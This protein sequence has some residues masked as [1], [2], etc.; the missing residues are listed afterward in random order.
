M[1]E[2]MPLAPL[3]A[4]RPRLV[5]DDAGEFLRVALICVCLRVGAGILCR[6]YGA[7]DEHWQALEAAHGLA[8]G[9]G[10]PTWEW[11][12]EIRL[13]SLAPVGALAG[14]AFTPLRTAALAVWGTDAA[15][16]LPLAAVWAAPRVA[17]AASALVADAAVYFLALSTWGG[18]ARAARAA[19]LAHAGSWPALI[20]GARAS[21]NAASA[22][23][24]A[25][26][27]A[28][29]QTAGW[30]GGRGECNAQSQ[31][32]LIPAL[33]LGVIAG[34][35][36]AAATVTHP[37]VAAALVGFAGAVLWSAPRRDGWRLAVSAVCGAV[38]VYILER[39]ADASIRG[40]SGDVLS[41][42]TVLS[43]PPPALA[44]VRA[45]VIEGVDS[46]SGSHFT[47]WYLIIGVPAVLG[48][49]A[50]A[51]VG[52]LC[53]AHT[54]ATR[55]PI[56]AAAALVAAL[57]LAS[58]KELRYLAPF[59]PLV[60]VYAGRGATSGGA[61]FWAKRW[62]TPAAI[63]INALAAAYV[64]AV[65]QRGPVAAV[66][67][68]AREGKRLLAMSKTT[69]SQNQINTPTWREQWATLAEELAPLAMHQLMPCHAAPA[70][71]TLHWP[72][73]FLLL[74][75]SPGAT[76]GGGVASRARDRA[77]SAAAAAGGAACMGA[78][79]LPPISESRAWVLN[80]TALLSAMYGLAPKRPRVCMGIG[81]KLTKTETAFLP[82]WASL[83]E[84]EPKVQGE[85]D[86]AAAKAEAAASALFSVP[87]VAF[88]QAFGSTSC[89]AALA[90]VAPLPARS[91]PS[92]ML[93]YNTDA[94]EP[95][96]AKW[97]SA[98]GF[99]VAAS[100]S[101]G[102][103][104]G[105]SHAK[106]EGRGEPSAVIVFEHECWLQVMSS[107]N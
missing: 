97:L 77:L 33:A 75:C 48:V 78:A 45:N 89:A 24:L 44:F 40:G 68:V 5:G 58:H 9:A 49:W 7:P 53:A 81:E 88:V 94:A 69:Q 6:S 27:L 20:F 107:S 90:A 50:P 41:L 17:A 37:T 47:L 96:V 105:D 3:A 104:Q 35:A 2:V 103:V 65:H 95:G 60:A 25:V 18:D 29:A 38:V 13:R 30:G 11:W 10:Y 67:F 23:L 106:A 76:L 19:A 8:F 93:L 55:A 54:Q 34:A 99:A 62:A 80:K 64:L 16:A 57:S 46:L 100:F 31:S 92:H 52:G 51:I 28:A 61:P 15:R 101:M 21:A 70:Y 36:G 91:L 83:I 74:D 72:I 12:P 84:P 86:D 85:T 14:V 59:V 1:H 98:Q 39:I 66:E 42:A 87:P 56:V 43:A 32:R 26:A 102:H 73:E 22:A 71:A 63:A 4:K 82:L 79:A